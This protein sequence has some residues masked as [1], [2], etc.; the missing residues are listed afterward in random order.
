MPALPGV[1][2]LRQHLII[3]P[4]GICQLLTDSGG[5]RREWGVSVSSNSS[6]LPV[7]VAELTAG[8]QRGYI[9]MGTMEGGVEIP[10]SARGP[11]W[12]PVYVCHMERRVIG[13]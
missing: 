3:S 6:P 2:T 7:S 11:H 9:R 4:R 10:N 1:K 8:S 12:A 13:F 5:E